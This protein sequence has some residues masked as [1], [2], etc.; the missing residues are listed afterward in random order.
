MSWDQ[1]S[2]ELLADLRRTGYYPELVADVLDVAIAGEPIIAHLVQAETTFGEELRRHLTTMVLTKTRLVTAHVDDHDGDPNLDLPASA[3][4]TTE[5]ITLKDIRSVSLTHLVAQPA[6]YVGGS[7]LKSDELNLS[8]GWGGASR[9]DLEPADCGNP[10]CDGDHGYVGSAMPDDIV[11]R[12][13]SA[14]EGPE[15]VAKAMAFARALSHATVH[16]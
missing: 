1:L 4:A 5:S 16:L 15:A 10:E 8:I 9:L 2:P 3:A 11:V 13:A 14:A 12:V 7:G 6:D